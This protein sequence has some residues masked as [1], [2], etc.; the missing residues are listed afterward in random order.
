MVE[1]DP[2]DSNRNWTTDVNAVLECLHNRQE[3]TA[4][5]CMSSGCD[6]WVG[7]LSYSCYSEDRVLKITTFGDVRKEV[8]I[9]ERVRGL[10]PVPIV[11]EHGESIGLQYILMEMI[12]NSVMLSDFNGQIKPSVMSQMKKYI[13]LMRSLPPPPGNKG[14]YIEHYLHV[15][16]ANSPYDGPENLVESIVLGSTGE[17]VSVP[18]LEHS[19][20][21]L[22]HCDLWP[23]N[24]MVS[25]DGTTVT[26]IIDWQLAGYYPDFYEHFKYRFV[27]IM[28][29]Q[30]TA[31]A[32]WID[33]F[34]TPETALLKKY[35]NMTYDGVKR[36]WARHR[37]E[38]P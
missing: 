26:S 2:Y 17:K 15:F 38:H 31:L 5:S 34:S 10:I 3:I 18:K 11:Y 36:R 24:V 25:M 16:Y 13:S 1:R 37:A 23:E 33:M 8:S 21:V 7:V 12:Q 29:K 19:K 20:L 30:E 27:A 35:E 4:I 9:M 22:S 28:E 32:E 6:T 14:D